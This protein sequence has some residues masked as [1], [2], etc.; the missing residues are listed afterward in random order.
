MA[1]SPEDIE[2]HETVSIT[3]DGKKVAGML[4]D[5]SIQANNI[6]YLIL[7]IG[8]NFDIDSKKL[9]RRC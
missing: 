5:A 7:G 3:L 6:D 9:E 1:V 8:I 4:V 2:I